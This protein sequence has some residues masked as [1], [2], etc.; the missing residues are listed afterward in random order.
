MCKSYCPIDKEDTL[1]AGAA[2]FLDDKAKGQMRLTLRDTA[3][4]HDEGRTD[5]G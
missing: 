1:D 4:L 3:V 5:R 2:Y